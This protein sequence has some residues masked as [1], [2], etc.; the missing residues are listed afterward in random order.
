MAATNSDN[1]LYSH[2]QRSGVLEKTSTA[3][4]KQEDRAH[5]CRTT[6]SLLRQG[7]LFGHELDIGDS[8]I[9]TRIA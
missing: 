4:L 9:R 1:V 8:L 2:R 3:L 6:N 5:T 7:T